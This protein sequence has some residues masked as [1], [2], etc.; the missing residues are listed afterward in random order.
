[1]A[2]STSTG[3]S[4]HLARLA[5]CGGAALCLGVA[6]TGWLDGRRGESVSAV[7]AAKTTAVT[8]GRDC[9]LAEVFAES[10]AA[11]AAGQPLLRFVDE[12]LDGRMASKGRERSEAAVELQR[13]EALAEVEIAWRRR[14]LQGEIYQTQLQVTQLQQQRLS[15]Q[16]EQIAWQEHLQEWVDWAGDGPSELL[17]QPVT[18]S[19]SQPDAQRLQALLKEDAAASALE[20]LDKQLEL[21]EARLKELSQLTTELDQ[22]VRVSVGVDVARA[23]RD[24]VD[25]ELAALE[26]QRAALTI[27]STGHGTV[28]LWHKQPGDRVAA[29]E[30]VVELLDEAQL[31]LVAQ[32][33]SDVVGR[34]AAGQKLM[35]VF[36]GKDRRDGVVGAIPPQASAVGSAT[37]DAQLPL[38]I[39]PSGKLWPKLPIG[40]RVQVLL[41]QS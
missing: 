2:D 16:V 18:L 25:A 5:V 11:V 10:G 14:E 20:T 28:G 8:A 35:L 38:Q 37:E 41:P 17:I 29:G 6:V 15:R 1:M 23:R 9:R 21:S 33:S 26:E 22:K 7:L 4:L 27:C 40:S 13:V 12:R 30:V 3:G 24:R 36:P 32:V 34:I 39:R 31:S 19:R